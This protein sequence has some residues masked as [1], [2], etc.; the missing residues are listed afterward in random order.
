MV[1]LTI[2]R[3]NG[4]DYCVAAHSVIADKFSNVPVE[5]TDAIRNGA[6]IQEIKLNALNSF[7]KEVFITR[8]RPSKTAVAAF[9]TA[10]YAEVHVLS[11][12]LAISVK[13]LSNYANHLFE[14]PLDSMFKA[15]EWHA[16]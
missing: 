5:V 12:V 13:V 2:S 9:S 1:F 14:T 10:G 7:T 4:C 8:G 6:E 16:E 11:I 15:R 3:E